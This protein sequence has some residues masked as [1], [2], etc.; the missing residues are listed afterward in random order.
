MLGTPTTDWRAD[1]RAAAREAILQ[2]AKELA[3]EHGLAG[4]SLRDLARRLGMAAPSLYGYFTSKTAL[5]DALFAQGYRELLA[6]ESVPQTDVRSHLRA[7]ARMNV[8]FSLADPVRAQLLFQRTVPGFEPSPESWALAQ[9]AYER[10]LAPLLRHPHVQQEDLDLVTALLTGLVSQ[11]LSNDPGGDRW[12]R[13]A[14]DAVD[15]LATRIE[16]RASS[17]PEGNPP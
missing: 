4:I 8:A 7:L 1:R 17:R 6:L 2:A 13:L 14:E 12:T 3:A 16:A 5:Y 9:Q 10:H 15:L 11:Q